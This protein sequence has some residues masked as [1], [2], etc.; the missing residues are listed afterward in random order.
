MIAE[1]LEEGELADS[2]NDETSQK[3]PV[4]TSP[5]KKLVSN[6]KSSQDV[7]LEEGEIVSS[8]EEQQPVQEKK[9]ET[10]ARKS[11]QKTNPS[12]KEKRSIENK[13]NRGDKKKKGDS[14]INQTSLIISRLQHQMYFCY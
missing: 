4:S 2:D 13:E 3:P 6:G 14:F 11:E 7:E 5:K 8:D 12:N 10:V 9:D 1:E